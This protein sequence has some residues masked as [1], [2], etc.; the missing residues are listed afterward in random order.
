MKWIHEHKGIVRLVVLVGM[1]IAIGGPWEF[2]RI[3]VPAQ[4]PCSPPNI[5]LEGDFCG[6]PL[7]LAWFVFSIL[8]GLAYIVREADWGSLRFA[9]LLSEL[10]IYL[11]VF[12]LIFPVVSTAVLVL[13]GEGRRWQT[14]HIAGLVLA[15]GIA[16]LQAWSGNYTS[17]W[18]FRLLWGLWLYILL[19]ASLFVLEAFVFRTP[20]GFA[21]ESTPEK[22]AAS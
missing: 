11:F 14:L 17:G 19:T 18:I 9:A 13:R 7:S 15:A 2:D 5:R 16:G 8:G 3:H 22:T 4:Y 6:L 12:L 10:P 20:P 21:K 1:V